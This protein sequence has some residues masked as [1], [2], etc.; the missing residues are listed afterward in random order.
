[1]TLAEIA[2]AWRL[3]LEQQDHRA[4]SGV[5]LIYAGKVYGWKDRLRDAGH[6]RPGA[7]AVD[8]DGHEF[9]AEGG[10]DYNGAKC[11]VARS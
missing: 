6:E 1:M 9:T 3:E 10:D 11:W 7:V 2:K 5:V 4:S 8:T